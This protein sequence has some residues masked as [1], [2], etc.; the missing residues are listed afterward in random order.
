M[1]IYTPET[2]GANKAI[3]LVN[4]KVHD[5]VTYV[6]TSKGFIDKCRWP[7]K[8]DKYRKRVLTK[9]VR[10]KVEVVFND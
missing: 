8:L 10:G 4:G 9:R 7:I 5:K 3:V 1:A 2:P 6:D